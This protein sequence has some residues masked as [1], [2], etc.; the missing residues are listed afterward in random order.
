MKKDV[1]GV[2]IDDISID[3]VVDTVK[4]WLSKKGRYYIVTP[5]PEIV[6]M[7]QKDLELKKIINQADLS[8][9]DGNGLKLA[10]DIE[11]ISPGVDV[12]EVLVKMASVWAATIGLL[13]GRGDVAKNTAERLK[14]KYPKLIVN[15]ALS[16]PVIP[17]KVGA[18]TNNDLSIPDQ[19]RDQ[20]CDILFVAFGPPKQEEWM[21]KNLD[22]IPVK[23]VMGVGGSFDYISGKVLRAPLWVRNLKLE[24]LF[25]LVRQ[26]WRIN[27]QLVLIK[28]LFL[29]LSRA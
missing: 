26:P 8:L 23:V 9:A 7:A 11:C 28:Y 18:Y 21:A 5:N 4:E 19:V 16:G 1:L 14:K 15:Y 6:V 17:I 12:M 27:R 3:Q 25:R 13:G 29:L 2:K 10:T 22:K 20:R 24:W